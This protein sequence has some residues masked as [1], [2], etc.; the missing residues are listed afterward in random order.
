MTRT[1]L[2]RLGYILGGLALMSQAAW[3][4]LG[5]AEMHPLH[6]ALQDGFQG[7][8]VRIS[9]NGQSVFDRPGVTTDLRISRADAVDVSAPAQRVRIEATVDPGGVSGA[10]EVDVVATPHV[11]IDFVGGSLR[12]KVSAEPFAYM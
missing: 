6:I 3:L 1:R 2:L 8:H 12:F 5:A 9:V 7:Q 11:A 4:S 10:T